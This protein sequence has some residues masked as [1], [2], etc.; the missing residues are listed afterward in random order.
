MLKGNPK[1]TDADKAAGVVKARTQQVI[2]E[3]D[4]AAIQTS[5]RKI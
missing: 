1:I 3:A 2:S 4:N 5:E